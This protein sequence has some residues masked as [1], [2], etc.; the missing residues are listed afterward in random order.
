MPARDRLIAG[1]IELM[2]RN[3]VAGTGL[4]Q[5]LDLSKTARRS[6]YLNFP[7]GKA[8]LVADATVASGQSISGAID[9]LAGELEPVAAVQAFFAMWRDTLTGSD[10]TS[11][12]P[13]MAAAQ[14][15]SE[16]PKAAD[17]AGEVFTEWEGR[18]AGHLESRDVS[19]DEAAQ[20]A[21]LTIAAIE[22]AVVMSLATKSD[23]PMQRAE[24]ALVGL[25]RQ[26]V[27]S[28]G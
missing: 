3:G 25:Y 14:G 17:I 15:R 5:L 28:A 16:A 13:I 24:D 23:A 12:C 22:G 21:T 11:G 26:K 9:Q 19:P 20:L 18:L 8:E 2:R 1:A 10:F 4:N 7:G 27:G 6:L